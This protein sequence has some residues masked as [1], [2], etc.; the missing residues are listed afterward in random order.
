MSLIKKA[1]QTIFEILPRQ[2]LNCHRFGTAGKDICHYCADKITFGSPARMATPECPLNLN[3]PGKIYLD[4]YQVV[5]N[6]R[7]PI[8]VLI[9]TM[10]YDSV[11]PVAHILGEWLWWW[12]SEPWRIDG[13]C[14]VPLHPRRFGERGFNQAQI[15][16]ATYAQ[17]AHLPHLPLLERRQ[18]T[19]NQAATT[20]TQ[21]QTQLAGIFGV[22][23]KFLEE[24]ARA[25]LAGRNI[26]IIDDVMTS[27]HTFNECARALKTQVGIAHVYALAL[28]GKQN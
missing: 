7:P 16:A 18:H 15:M 17:L 26:L 12:G 2:C 19:L 8:S 9:K 23:E 25:Q 20:L 27:G 24:G 10:K 1:F 13:I 28:A 21:R 11:K 4:G 5:T 14:H 22:K 6:F 3:L